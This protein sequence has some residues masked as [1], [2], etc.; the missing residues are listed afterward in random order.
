MNLSKY[1]WCL[2]ELA[3]MLRVCYSVGIGTYVFREKHEDGGVGWWFCIEP[4]AIHSQQMTAGKLKPLLYQSDPFWAVK[5]S[6]RKERSSNPGWAVEVVPGAVH[7]QEILSTRKNKGPQTW[8][9]LLPPPPPAPCLLLL[10]PVCCSPISF[11]PSWCKG[12]CGDAN[13][14]GDFPTLTVS[15]LYWAC[16]TQPRS[17]SPLFAEA[18]AAQCEKWTWRLGGCR[19]SMWNALGEP[20]PTYVK[21]EGAGY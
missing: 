21:W 19:W 14:R 13:P 10:S 1:S 4:W 8:D 2:A 11:L 5:W 6:G 20:S 7:V 12:C 16:C 15:I 18:N 17:I 9:A 3:C